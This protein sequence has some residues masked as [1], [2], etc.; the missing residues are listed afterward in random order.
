M[1]SLQAILSLLEHYKYLVIF[2]VTIIEGPIAT[3]LSGFLVSLKY[4][5][6]PFTYILL[7]VGDIIGDI[8]HYLIGKHWGR[9]RIKKWGRFLGYNE[10]TEKFLENHFVHHKGKTFILSKISHGLGTAVQIAAGIARVD[11]WEFL[12]WNAL[13]T[14]PKTL[15]LFLIGFYAGNSYVKINEYLGLIGLATALLLLGLIV[16]YVLLSKFSNRYFSR[17]DPKN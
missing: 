8:L 14:F 3:I 5:N 15:I 1:P 9:E 10:K 11:F 17:G 7:V 4:L 16:A 12:W 6:G 2:P 13:A